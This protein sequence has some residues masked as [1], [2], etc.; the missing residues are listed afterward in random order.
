M[1]STSPETFTMPDCRSVALR[2]AGHADHDTVAALLRDLKLPTEGVKEWL[3]Q[4]WVA[5]HSGAVVGVAGM[6]R[7]RDSGLLRSVAVSQ[8]WRNSGI[9]GALVDRV[10]EDARA[11][12]AR[13]IYLLTTTAEH[14]F[15]RLGFARIERESAPATVC[16][17]AEFTVA[18]PSSAVVMRRA[19]ND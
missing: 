16:A 7:Y 3:D 9:G 10:L 17:S 6:E 19:V 13:E 2:R 14:Y 11:A 1:P 18:C 5:E 15:T 8:A 4:F 12:G